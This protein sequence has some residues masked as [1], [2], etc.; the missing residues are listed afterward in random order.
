L[1]N[2]FPRHFANSPLTLTSGAEIYNPLKLKNNF[3]LKFFG[4]TE[5]FLRDLGT[6]LKMADET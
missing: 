1:K 2:S 4:I 3:L 5:R 6:S